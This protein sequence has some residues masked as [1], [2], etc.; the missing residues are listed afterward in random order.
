MSPAGSFEA[1]MA[2]IQGGADSV[3]FGV[4]NLNMRSRSANNFALTDLSKIVRICRKHKVKTYL[5]VNIVMYDSELRQMRKLL[6]SACK[7]GVDAVIASDQAVIEYARNI[8]LE[9]HLSTQINISNTESLRFYARYA[10]VVVLARELSLDKVKKIY[11]AIRRQK[12]TGPSGKLV[13]IEMFAHGAL[14]MSISGKCYLSLHE[15]NHSANRGE[16][17]QTCRKAYTVTE[18]ESGMQLDI[19]NEYIMS[20]KDLCTVGFLHKL[21]DA[22]VRVL[23][24]EG[25]ARSGEYVKTVTRAYKEASLALANGTYTPENIVR[26]TEQLRTVFNR[27][28]WDGY[29]L[30]QKLGEW[31]DAYGSKATLRKHYIGKVTN[32]FKKLGVAEFLCEAGELKPGDQVSVN[33]PTTGVVETVVT[34]IHGQAGPVEKASKGSLF[35]F[36]VPELVRRADKVY[37]LEKVS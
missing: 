3:Y 15:Q 36:A 5:T 35:A 24:I 18:R 21:A 2:A 19:E 9:V 22:G 31:S 11:H 17:L 8:G 4:G 20:P 13:R 23:K 37:R 16:C 34:E 29:Y 32:F 12:I 25:R 30:G 33:G 10:D 6:D 26:W 7:H 1:L 14:C 27:G 28:F